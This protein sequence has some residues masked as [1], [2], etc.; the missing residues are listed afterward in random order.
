M[1]RKKLSFEEALKQL[2]SIAERIE[3]G[4]IGL[5]ESITEYEKGMDLVN[6]CRE[7]L[8]K[9]EQ[10]IQQ[11]QQRADGTLAPSEFK[12]EVPGGGGEAD[13]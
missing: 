13:S 11:V 10:K 9:A 3:R 5:E 12:P 6:H 1:S 7:I 8:A 4:E 2:E